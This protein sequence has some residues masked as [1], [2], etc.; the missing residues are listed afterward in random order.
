MVKAKR[1]GVHDSQDRHRQRR[2]SV[3]RTNTGFTGYQ[4]PRLQD[5]YT[6]VDRREAAARWLV[7]AA[8]LETTRDQ[9]ADEFLGTYP[10][11]QQRLCDLF[12]RMIECDAAINRLHF[13]RPVNVSKHLR[14]TEQEARGIDAFS[15]SQPSIVKDGVVLPDFNDSARN[16]WPPRSTLDPAMFTPVL[17]HDRRITSDSWRGAEQDRSTAPQ[18]NGRQAAE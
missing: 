11:V 14:S 13:A 15:L 10:D 16:V 6:V 8:K 1:R 2:R 4:L 7:E 12:R 5:R 17:P 18:T 9:L 3:G